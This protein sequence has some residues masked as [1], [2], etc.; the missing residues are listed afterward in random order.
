MLSCFIIPTH[1]GE[2]IP[3]SISTAFN[4]GNSQ[5]ISKYFNAS[6]ELVLL[7]RNYQY[8]KP[9]AQQALANFFREY[10]PTAYTLKHEG[11]KGI[12][13]YAIGNLQTAKGSFRVYLLI[14]GS[15]QDLKIHQLRI[16]RNNE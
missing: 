1:A 10:T 12:F 6:I 2:A 16:E 9:E 7:D 8:T 3:Q 14:K 11:E 13:H 5:E 15:G 4:S